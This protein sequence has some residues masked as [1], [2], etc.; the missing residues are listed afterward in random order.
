MDSGF[1]NTPVSR[2]GPTSRLLKRKSE[3]VHF[4][5]F[6]SRLDQINVSNDFSFALPNMTLRQPKNDMT[7]ILE[8]TM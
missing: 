2:Q 5:E 1:L 6:D 7:M 4:N 8:G 3:R